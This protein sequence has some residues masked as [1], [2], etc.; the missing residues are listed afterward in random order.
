MSAEAVI[1]EVLDELQG[2]DHTEEMRQQ[3]QQ[4]EFLIRYRELRPTV[5]VDT[6][7]SGVL[8]TARM[9]TPAR[10]RRIVEDRFWRAVLTRFAAMDDVTLAYNTLRTIPT[11]QNDGPQSSGLT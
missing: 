7:S 11:T 8:L 5:Y 2:T 1:R 4:G 6:A 3:L 9:I 10:G